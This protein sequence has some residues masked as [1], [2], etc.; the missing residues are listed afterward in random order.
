MTEFNIRIKKFKEIK[1]NS[2]CLPWNQNN[3]EQEPNKA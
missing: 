2:L 1:K 3:M